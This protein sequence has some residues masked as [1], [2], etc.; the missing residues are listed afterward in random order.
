[1]KIQSHQLTDAY[2][3]SYYLSEFIKVVVIAVSLMLILIKFV[4]PYLN[5]YVFTLYQIYKIF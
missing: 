5:S 1:M 3:N 4:L 2:N